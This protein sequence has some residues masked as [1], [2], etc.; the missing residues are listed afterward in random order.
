MVTR[1]ECA[2]ER[3]VLGQGPGTLGG[4]VRAAVREQLDREPL[5]GGSGGPWRPVR[6]GSDLTLQMMFHLLSK[7]CSR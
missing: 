7:Y 4:G 1:G 5:S 6:V 3:G 2:R